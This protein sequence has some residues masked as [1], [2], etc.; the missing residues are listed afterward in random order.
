MGKNKRKAHILPA[1]LLILTL[2]L[3]AC[4]GTQE[5]VRST[6][7]VFTFMGKDISLGE[8]YL[9]AKTIAQDYERTY[10]NDVWNLAVTEKDGAKTDLL[11][12]TRKD[13]IDN[14]VRVKVLLAHAEQYGVSLT[15]DDE[16][17]VELETEAFWKNLTDE[18]LEEMELDR[19][20]VRRVIEENKLAS[21]VYQKMM[22]AAGIEVS[23]EKARM[24]TIYD[25]YFPCYT[26]TDNGTV[27]RLPE[28]E[29]KAQYDRAVQ[30]YN[31]LISPVDE[32]KERDIETLAAYYG[33]EDA[34][35][36][37]KSP[38]EMK[39]TYGEDITNMLYSLEDGSYS[40]VTET[41]Y[42]Y[43]IFYMSALTDRDATDKKKERIE[44]EQRNVYFRSLYEGW[45]K[46]ADSS[47]SYNRS[48]DFEVYDK[49]NFQ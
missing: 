15:A 28:E 33:L 42:G 13:I 40:L 10:G 21:L 11:T 46:S 49:I 38:E 45:L 31:T 17:K 12:V 39:E 16:E 18:Q 47:Y 41:E 1:V 32:N 9:Y 19:N 8:V 27:L 44:R 34:G 6:T 2:L 23:D 48:V 22:D 24:T 43:H 37:T 20:L 36:V 30:A 14:I 4:G 7:T 5:N 25:M 26:E 35:Y 3:S 29:K